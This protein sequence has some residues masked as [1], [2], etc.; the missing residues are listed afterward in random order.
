MYATVTIKISVDIG[1]KINKIWHDATEKIS[2]VDNLTSVLTYQTLPPQFPENPNCMGLD[3]DLELHKSH[4]VLI[5]S[6][7]WSE[8]KETEPMSKLTQDAVM[9]IE[10]VS[11]EEGALHEWKYMN[12]AGS[13]Q[14]PVKSYGEKTLKELKDVSRKYDPKGIFQKQAVGFKLGSD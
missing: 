13:W 2:D 1:K 14:D 8:A 10:K 7:Y 12:Y 6:I 4:L 5:I 3:P 11:R 9:E